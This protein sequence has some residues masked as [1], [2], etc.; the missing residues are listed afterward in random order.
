MVGCLLI[1]QVP[2]LISIFGLSGDPNIMY[3]FV[4]RFCPAPVAILAMVNVEYQA[5]NYNDRIA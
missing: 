3:T 4:I 2:G 1:H 5:G